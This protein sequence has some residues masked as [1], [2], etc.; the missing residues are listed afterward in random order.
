MSTFTENAAAVALAIVAVV[1]VAGVVAIELLGLETSSTLSGLA[2][3][4]I[5]YIGK[6]VVDKRR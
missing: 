3:T 4:I 5:G 1:V 2:G 6:S